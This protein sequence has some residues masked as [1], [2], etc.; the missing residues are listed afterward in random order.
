MLSK[1][2]SSTIFWVFGMTQLGIEP[3]SQRPLYAHT[4]KR[5]IQNVLRLIQNLDL[6]LTSDFCMV[7]TC[8][9]IKSGIWIFLYLVLEDFATIK[10][11]AIALLSLLL[12]K[13]TKPYIYICIVIT[14]R[15]FHFITT[16][17][18]GCLKLG[19]NPTQLY[20][21]LSI[22]PLSQQAYHIS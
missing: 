22:R 20:I 14:D 3:Q 6:L 7:F 4:F 10:W 21:R 1:E 13:E 16:L 18:I 15:L 9:E 17:H 12:H 5:V 2:A 19:S 8:I 11:S